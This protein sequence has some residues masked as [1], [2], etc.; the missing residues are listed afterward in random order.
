MTIHRAIKTLPMPK[1]ISAD[2]QCHGGL[3]H[4]GA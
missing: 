3:S 4:A 2:A 1:P